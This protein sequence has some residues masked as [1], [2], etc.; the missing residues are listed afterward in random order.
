VAVPF[1]KSM[2]VAQAGRALAGPLHA[3]TSSLSLRP[4]PQRLFECL[5]PARTIDLSRTALGARWAEY[6]TVRALTPMAISAATV[7]AVSLRERAAHLLANRFQSFRRCFLK[8]HFSGSAG[9]DR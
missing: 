8:T 3:I 9:A 5:W 7:S 2:G 6:D 1:R 4:R